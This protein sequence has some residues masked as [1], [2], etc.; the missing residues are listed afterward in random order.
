MFIFDALVFLA[1]YCLVE[2]AEVVVCCCG[3]L[4][5]GKSAPRTAAAVLPA[6]I[7]AAG[8]PFPAAFAGFVV[9]LWEKFS[10]STC[11]ATYIP[12]AC[13]KC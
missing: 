3:C 9:L 2:R 6:L 4:R 11:N 1:V 12:R 13:M 5:P 7:G 8:R 10:L